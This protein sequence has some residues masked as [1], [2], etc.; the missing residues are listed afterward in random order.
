[1]QAKT[2]GGSSLVTSLSTLDNTVLA[3]SFMS[4][5][6]LFTTRTHQ[7]KAGLEP[8]SA[9]IEVLGSSR[10]ISDA[11]I[12]V[13]SAGL[14]DSDCLWAG[15]YPDGLM[16][17][18]RPEAELD[19]CEARQ[20]E[21][22]RKQQEGEASWHPCRPCL[23]SSCCAVV[24]AG[25]AAVTAHSSPACCD[26]PGVVRCCLIMWVLPLQLCKHRMLDHSNFTT[27]LTFSSASSSS[28]KLVTCVLSLSL[29]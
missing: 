26:C 1:M 17:L 4:S 21:R 7:G 5:L 18:M 10:E 27:A 24:R 29:Q 12:Q 11:P 20:R 22:E 8:L 9:T 2:A 6:S 28:C 23:S 19:A 16:L 14:V 13:Q 25:W 15:A 3:C